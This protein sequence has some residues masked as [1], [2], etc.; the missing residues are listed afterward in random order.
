MFVVN[1]ADGRILHLSQ[2][3]DYWYCNGL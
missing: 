1:S 3:S 2:N